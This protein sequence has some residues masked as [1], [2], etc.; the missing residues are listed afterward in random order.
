[1]HES[2]ME[3]VERNL[4]GEE[5]SGKAVLEFGS[6]DVNGSVRPYVESYGPSS[7]LGIDFRPGP[8]VDE[9]F[10]L[11][12]PYSGKCDLLISTEMLEHVRIWQHAVENMKSCLSVGGILIVTTRSPG[13]PLHEYPGDFWRFTIQD[14]SAIFADMNIYALEVDSQAP[15]LFMKARKTMTKDP[16]DLSKIQVAQAP[17]S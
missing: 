1:M 3:F 17:E 13:F 5:I 8:R 7:Y 16:V 2:V 14:F 12:C 4:A 6:L 10:D 11:S 15:G 9:I